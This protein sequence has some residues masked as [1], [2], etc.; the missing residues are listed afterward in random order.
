MPFFRLQH[1]SVVLHH[2]CC[3]CSPGLCCSEGPALAGSEKPMC[4]GLGCGRECWG[5]SQPRAVTP[6]RGNPAPVP[7]HPKGRANTPSPSRCCGLQGRA[8]AAGCDQGCQARPGMDPAHGAR[9]ELLFLSQ[10]SSAWPGWEPLEPVRRGR[11]GSRST[12]QRGC[13]AWWWQGEDSIVPVSLPRPQLLGAGALGLVL[14]ALQPLCPPV[15]AP[16][17]AA[18]HPVP[19]PALLRAARAPVWWS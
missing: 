12:A 19:H 10:Q 2:T 16:T 3:P 9:E 4:A 13:P 17:Q 8:G 1:L 5:S 11:G 15:C 14:R 18:L 6:E 7:P